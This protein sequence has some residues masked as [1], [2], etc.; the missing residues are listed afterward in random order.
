MS[1]LDQKLA[2]RDERLAAAMRL[3]QSNLELLLTHNMLISVCHTFAYVMNGSG[4][5]YHI[6][7]RN[8]SKTVANIT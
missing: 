3:P 5:S 2:F 7:Y 1:A 6:I 8:E 4:Y